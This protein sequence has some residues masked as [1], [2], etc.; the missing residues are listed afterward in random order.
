MKRRSLHDSGSVMTLSDDAT[1]SVIDVV[2]DRLGTS[3]LIQVNSL[4]FTQYYGLKLP[5]YLCIDVATYNEGSIVL[6][7]NQRKYYLCNYNDTALL[8][9]YT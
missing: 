4:Q 1:S 5:S 3:E 2:C 7:T 8:I 9:K 6:V